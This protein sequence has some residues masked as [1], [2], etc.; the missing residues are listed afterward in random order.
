MFRHQEKWTILQFL[1]N[2]QKHETWQSLHSYILDNKEQNGVTVLQSGPN[3]T[4]PLKFAAE[5]WRELCQILTDFKNLSPLDRELNFQQTSYNICIYTLNI[6]LH[7]FVEYK[8][9]NCCKLRRKYNENLVIL[10]LTR[11]RLCRWIN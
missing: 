6:L 3:E 8:M 1:Q 2:R 10:S 7:Y 9:K 5:L 11:T 4:A